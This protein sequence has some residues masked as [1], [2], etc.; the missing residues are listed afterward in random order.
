MD[1]SI[2]ESTSKEPVFKIV[3]LGNS[4][5]GKSSILLFYIKRIFRPDYNITIGL[6]FTS[7]RVEVEPGKEIKLQVWDTVDHLS[8][9][10]QDK[11]ISSQ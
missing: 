3:I 5:V 6:E 2:S 9:S 10:R 4:N 7:K 8:N 11:S 1:D